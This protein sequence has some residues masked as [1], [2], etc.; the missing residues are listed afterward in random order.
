MNITEPMVLR[1]DVVLIPVGDLS[2]DVRDKIDYDE[3]DY[4]ISRRH[5]R[6]ASQ[7]IDGETAAL[8]QLFKEPRTIVDAVILNSRALE[9][10]PETWLDE[11]LPHLGTFLH[12]GVLVSADAPDEEV[13]QT[14]EN[15]KSAGAWSVV[16][17]VSIIEDSEIYRVKNGDAEGALKLARAAVPFERSILANEA[18]VLERIGGAPAPRLLDQG[19]HDE[20]P[21][22]VM[23]WC[24]G[25]DAG[26]AA[27]QRRHDRARLLASACAIAD[28][29]VALH[30]R[31]ILHG[32]VHPRNVV[33]NDDGVVRLI[34]FGLGRVADDP[35]RVQRGGMYYFYEPELLAAEKTGHSLP[36]TFAGEQYSI[37][38]MLFL[39]LAGNHYLDFRLER[40]EM[41]RQVLEDPPLPFAKRGVP[42]WPEVEA[43]LVRALDK[44]P[45]KR[46]TSTREL[47]TALRTVHDAALAE[48]LVT[49]VSDEAVALLEERLRLFSRGGELFEAGF[50]V[51]PKAS[52]NYGCAGAAV[53]LLR[54]AEVRSDPALLALADVW[55]SRAYRE[56]GSPEAYYNAEIEL[57]PKTLGQITPYHTES[58]IHAAAAL[59]ANARGDLNALGIALERFLTAAS[60]PC[61]ELDLTLGRSGTLIGATILLEACRDTVPVDRLITFGNETLAEIWRLLDERPPIAQNS[62][63]AYL[64]TAHGWSG[65]L[66]AAMRWSAASGTALPESLPRRLDELAALRVRRGSASYWRRQTDGHPHDILSGWCNGSA[67]HVFTWTAAHTA[68]GDERW[69][70]LAEETARHT[71]EEP[72]YTAD[73]CCG[74]AGR[75]YALL[76]LYKHTG[77]AEWLSHARRLANHAA[78]VREEAPRTNS[79]WKGELGVAVLIADLESP[80]NAQMPFFE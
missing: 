5:G 43:I 56:L 52:I 51:A 24:T 69:L 37:A 57:D 33:I 2:A 7:I 58:G 74:S 22:L 62:G 32:D 27:S 80:E 28:A 65:Y 36:T 8:L 14:I 71:A 73:L 68:L 29:Y 13:E 76:N 31:G 55:K 12:N 53:G 75:A 23:E 41:I 11:L 63:G 20:N 30:E 17:L 18:A 6:S 1:R 72:M 45:G 35:V 34:D 9:K 48:A 77:A 61:D 15:G 16:H 40:A 47:A 21:Y 25:P 46:F 26:T 49:P 19:M 59:I 66:Y 70:R 44:D 42:P 54:I 60:L 79:L 67:G 50:T 39:L 64:G 10:D 4:T 78:S 38:A 3:G